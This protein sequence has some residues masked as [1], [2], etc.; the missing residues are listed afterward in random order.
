MYSKSIYC[1]KCLPLYTP[2]LINLK[3]MR[4][5]EI[6]VLGQFPNRTTRI[7]CFYLPCMLPFLHNYTVNLMKFSCYL[8]DHHFLLW[9]NLHSPP[10]LYLITM[11]FIY[12]RFTSDSV[13]FGLICFPDILLQLDSGKK[14]TGLDNND[15][16]FLGSAV[17]I[18]AIKSGLRR[19]ITTMKPFLIVGLF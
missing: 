15:T 12:M 11:Q 17:R 14:P 4:Y 10:I 19:K 8:L 7:N 2:H 9:Q 18:V 6:C 3:N 16:G 1:R 13:L 5:C